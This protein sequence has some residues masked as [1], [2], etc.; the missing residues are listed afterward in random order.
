L[1]ELPGLALTGEEQVAEEVETLHLPLRSWLLLWGS[2]VAVLGLLVL[3]SFLA[4]S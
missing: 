3:G 1:L 4:A 2:A